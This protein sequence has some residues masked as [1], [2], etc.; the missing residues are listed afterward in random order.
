MQI[1]IDDDT[2]DRAFRENL[3]WHINTIEKDLKILRAQR[4]LQTYQL[5]DKEYFEKLLPAL[6]IVGGYFGVKK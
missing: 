5:Q 6:K 2:L 4:K 3:S 1:E